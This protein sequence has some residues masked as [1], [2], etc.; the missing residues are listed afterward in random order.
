MVRRHDGPPDMRR[1][2]AEADRHEDEDRDECRGDG[3]QPATGI[4]PPEAALGP[5]RAP[6][7]DG[8][9]AE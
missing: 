5:A 9:E 1:D 8:A 2:V 3:E 4:A 6:Q 7:G